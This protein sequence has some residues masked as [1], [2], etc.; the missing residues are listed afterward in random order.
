M[1]LASREDSTPSPPSDPRNTDT[2]HLS[3]LQIEAF[4]FRITSA[5]GGLFHVHVTEG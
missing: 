2:E 3:R 5:G 1:V 4:D